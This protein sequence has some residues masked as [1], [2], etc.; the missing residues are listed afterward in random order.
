MFRKKEHMGV[1]KTVDIK[2][3][4][5]HSTNMSPEY[6]T[7]AAKKA[8]RI[9]SNAADSHGSLICLSIAISNYE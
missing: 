7:V 6:P 1:E 3:Q 5:P 8:M 4:T 9:R 2:I